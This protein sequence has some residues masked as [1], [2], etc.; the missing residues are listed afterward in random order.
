MFLAEEKVV[1]LGGGG[2]NDLGLYIRAS[3]RCSDR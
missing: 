3:S 2:G 1:S